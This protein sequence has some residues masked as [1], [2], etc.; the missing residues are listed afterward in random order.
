MLT[1]KRGK[2]WWQLPSG[3]PLPPFGTEILPDF[4]VFCVSI[5]NWCGP[6]RSSWQPDGW[7]A[8][9]YRSSSSS[10]SRNAA[11]G[12]WTS[13]NYLNNWLTSE[14]EKCINI[15]VWISV[16]FLP[17]PLSIWILLFH[18]SSLATSLDF[19][20]TRSSN[21]ST[22]AIPRKESRFSW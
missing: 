19:C 4:T 3:G 6:A 13:T 1:K 11:F 14:I 9:V 5:P 20:L 18:P 17:F 21:F 2:I 16:P 8:N 12:K 10:S 22:S 7:E 15:V